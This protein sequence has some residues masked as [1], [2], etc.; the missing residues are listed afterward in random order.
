MARWCMCGTEQPPYDGYDPTANPAP[1]PEVLAAA[2]RLGHTMVPEQVNRYRDSKKT[3]QCC[4]GPI[5]IED[6]FFNTNNLL[7]TPCAGQCTQDPDIGLDSILAGMLKDPAGEIDPY[8]VD[9]LRNM[10]FP[11]M[12]RPLDLITVRHPA[13]CVLSWGTDTHCCS[14]VRVSTAEHFAQ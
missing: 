1:F 3:V 10:L 13:P 5:T 7:G 8:V 11:F 4:G 14:L 12:D 6:A 2:L 9:A